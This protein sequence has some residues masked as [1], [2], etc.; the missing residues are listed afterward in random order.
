M[1]NQIDI[2]STLI[3]SNF[4]SVIARNENGKI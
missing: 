1:V 4:D 2:K 3:R